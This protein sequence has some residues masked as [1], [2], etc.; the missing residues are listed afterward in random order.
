MVKD[1]PRYVR[2]STSYR[3]PELRGFGFSREDFGLRENFTIPER[4]RFQVRGEWRNAFNRHRF[5]DIHT[6]PASPLV[7]QS[8]GVGGMPRQPQ[9]GIRM[10]F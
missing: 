8:V 10:D 3:H 7:G 6:N 2:G 1:P 5:T 4:F 9:V